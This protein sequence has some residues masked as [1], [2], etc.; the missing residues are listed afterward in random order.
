MQYTG[1]GINFIGYNVEKTPELISI[2][3][4][5]VRNYQKLDGFIKAV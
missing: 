1:F 2:I 4:W 5:K 3:G